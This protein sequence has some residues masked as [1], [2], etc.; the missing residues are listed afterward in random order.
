[1]SKNSDNK[2]T[3]KLPKLPANAKVKVIQINPKNIFTLL[4]VV[5]LAWMVYSSWIGRNGETIQYNDK[6][7]L[8]QIVDNYNS[9]GYESIEISG[10]EIQ[11][12]KPATETVVNGTIKKTRTIDRTRIPV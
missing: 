6:A 12:K 4:L 8:N 11:A 2:S 1:M 3:Q 10:R 9:G 5:A 7:G